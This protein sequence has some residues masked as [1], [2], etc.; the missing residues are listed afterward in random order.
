MDVTQL[1]VDWQK[2]NKE[3]LDQLIPLVYRELRKLAVHYLRQERKSHTL[4][5]TWLIHEAYLRMVQHDVPEF[6]NRVHF[7]GVA[8]NLMRQILVDHARKQRASKRG[9][10]ATKISLSDAEI[11]SNEKIM[12]VIAVDDALNALAKVD[13]RKCRA[14]ELRYFGGLSVEETAEVL[15][16]SVATLTR[17]LRMAEAW[18]RREI[19]GA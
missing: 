19:Q 8:A 13:Q 12:D 11:A 7:F 6:K 15:N 17:D 16:I 4:Q 2:G 5:P 10:G 3:A 14:I 18:L 1:L 9:G